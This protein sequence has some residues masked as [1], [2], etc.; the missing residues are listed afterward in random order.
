MATDGNP[1]QPSND[2]MAMTRDTYHHGNL[3]AELIRCGRELLARDGIHN[4]SL[5]AVTREAGVSHGAPRNEFAARDSAPPQDR[6][7]CPTS[8]RADVQSQ[9]GEH[10]RR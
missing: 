4:L 9:A 7:R 8:A 6:G 2:L 5:R 3:R 1:P 10:P